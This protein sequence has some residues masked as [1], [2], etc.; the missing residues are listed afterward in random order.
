[1]A[2]VPQMMVRAYDKGED[3]HVDSYDGAYLLEYYADDPRLRASGSPTGTTK[4]T[5]TTTAA[6]KWIEAEHVKLGVKPGLG[7][8]SPFFQL[9]ARNLEH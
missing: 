7:L 5:K 9:L 6:S 2:V 3:K 4:T 8:L 1:M